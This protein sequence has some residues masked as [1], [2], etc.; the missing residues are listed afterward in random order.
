[1]TRSRSPGAPTRSPPKRP[2]A[3]CASCARPC[4]PSVSAPDVV[5]AHRRLGRVERAFRALKGPE[6]AIRPI[7]HWTEPR[8]RAHV[9]LCLLAYCLR[10]RPG[11][12]WAPLLFRDEEPPV[13]LG[14]VA[15][16]RR[17][18]AALAK[19]SR[20]ELPDG[21]PVH[22]FRTLLAELATLTRSTFVLPGMPD[23]A[24]FEVAASPTSLQARAFGLLGLS[25]A[26]KQ[27]ERAT[28][29]RARPRSRSA[30]TSG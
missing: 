24:A 15:P 11:R 10:W 4:P 23:T 8:V 17:S 26:G 6:L 25:P 13:P 14:P 5:R 12:A 1:M 28:R 9:F 22:S 21:T 7:R 20:R 18:D 30:G 29:I 16:A 2:S 19:A 27:A 3:D